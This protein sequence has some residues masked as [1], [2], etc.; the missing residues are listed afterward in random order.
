MQI[1]EDY[2]RV[3]DGVSDLHG[4]VSAPAPAVHPLERLREQ[5]QTLR[6]DLGHHFTRLDEHGYLEEV[7]ARV[8]HLHHR[9]RRL[10]QEQAHLL[11]RLDD[12]LEELNAPDGAAPAGLSERVSALLDQIQAHELRKNLLA[13]DAYNIDP[14]ACD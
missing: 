8:P 4:L 9:L 13:M 5:L 1:A 10:R 3:R 11:A 2:R 7:E 12:V 14:G 6:E